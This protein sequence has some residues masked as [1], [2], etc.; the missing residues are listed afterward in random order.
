MTADLKVWTAMGPGHPMYSRL[1]E[2][3]EK[4]PVRRLLREA[5]RA[6]RCRSSGGP[7]IRPGVYFRMLMMGYFEGTSSQR[8]IA[9]KAA[10]SRSLQGF[11]G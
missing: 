11:L 2:T 8:G 6:L 9:W 5:V 3:L 7:S 1:E 4:A 10:D